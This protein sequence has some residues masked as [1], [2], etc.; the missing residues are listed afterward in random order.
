MHQSE[1]SAHGSMLYERIEQ[2]KRHDVFKV[3]GLNL[4]E[5]L[6]LPRDI[7]AMIL[8]ICAKKQKEEIKAMTDV[9]N[10]LNNV[11]QNKHD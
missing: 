3:F 9:T 7:C 11:M 2:F 5:F 8:E 10:Q 1:D 4:V 6:D